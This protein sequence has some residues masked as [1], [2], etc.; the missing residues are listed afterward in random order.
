M[1]GY[2]GKEKEE[3]NLLLMFYLYRT[4]TTQTYEISIQ[5]T[6]R[7]RKVLGLIGLLACAGDHTK[8]EIYTRA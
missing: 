3:V 8:K 6:T 1:V 7:S 5:S 2:H 4:P